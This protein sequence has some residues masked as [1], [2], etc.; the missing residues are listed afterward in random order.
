MLQNLLSNKYILLDKY[1]ITKNDT[2]KEKMIKLSEQ[3]QFYD[4]L[5]ANC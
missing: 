2:D 1:M 4:I 3:F 5:Y